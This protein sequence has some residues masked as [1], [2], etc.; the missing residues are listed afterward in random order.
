[1]NAVIVRMRNGKGIVV[2]VGGGGGLVEVLGGLVNAIIDSD[3][4]FGTS[5]LTIQKL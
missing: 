3:S 1:V 2:V 5:M 4:N